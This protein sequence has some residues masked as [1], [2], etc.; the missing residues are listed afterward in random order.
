MVL[1]VLPNFCRIFVYLPAGRRKFAK[2]IF[3]NQILIS[4]NALGQLFSPPSCCEHDPASIW[5]A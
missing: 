4:S 3:L 2:M 1:G 5:E